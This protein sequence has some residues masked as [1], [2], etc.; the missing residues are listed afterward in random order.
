MTQ[1]SAEAIAAAR[2]SFKTRGIP[3]SV[4][5]AQWALE[6]GWGKRMSG[7]H[8][9]FGIKAR[10]GEPCTSVVTHEVIKGKRV[11][12]T[13]LFRDYASLTEAFDA[14]AKLL[15]TGSAY[16]DFR[17]ALPDLVKAT[18]ALG[19]GTPARPRYA[20]DPAYGAKLMAIIR[21][22]ALTK[23]DA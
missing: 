7:K 4:T 1:P 19:G 12:V 11:A 15:Q 22:S 5:L 20:T 21:G 16:A 6:S 10:A 2:A 13:C 18:A 14:H 3:A 8:N 9:C 17:K 23:Y